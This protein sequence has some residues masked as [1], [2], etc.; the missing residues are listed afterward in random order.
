GATLVRPYDD[1]Y[2]I[3]GQGT[4]G[5]EIAAQ[6]HNA[7]AQLDAVLLPCGGGGLT[8]GSALALAEDCPGAEIYSV[9]PIGFDDTA[10]SLVAGDRLTND[11]SARSI[12]DALQMPTP[13]EMTFAINSRLLTGGLVVEDDAALAAMATAFSQLKVVAEPS[14]AVALAAVLEAVFPIKGKTVAVVCSG[15]NVDA[16]AFRAA[17]DVES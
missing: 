10:R 1:P 13:G 6:A 15:G 17:L 8:A 12:C 9:E 14:G 5:L 7:G 16:Q 11:A 4:V 2:V 3:A